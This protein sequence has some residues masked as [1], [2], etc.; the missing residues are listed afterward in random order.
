[1]K[2]K[3]PWY[4]F[5]D[6]ADPKVA[7]IYVDDFI[8]DWVD[9]FINEYLDTTSPLTAKAFI[10]DLAALPDTVKTIRVHINSPGGDVFAATT[11]A[12]S[13]RDQRV[14]KGRKVETVIDGLAASAASIIA[15]AGSPV[16]MAD[17]ALLMI[18]DPWSVAMGNAAE[19]RKAADVLDQVRDT[20]VAAYRWHSTL[21]PKAIEKLMAA[22][23]WL[24]AEA[25]QEGGFV[26]EVVSG[27]KAAASINPKAVERLNIPER[28]RARVDAL[29]A[30]TT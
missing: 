23:T 28:F 29:L 26:D 18:H 13:L 19:M 24:D 9:Q 10:A 16:R 25:A 30:T 8:G 17:N 12:N 20:I 27:L 5:R 4:R 22:E 14:T 1:M 11:I 21:E 2:A 15:M 7:E 6:A 3:A